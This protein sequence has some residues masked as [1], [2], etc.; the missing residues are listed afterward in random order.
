MS[1]ADIVLLIDALAWPV[2]IL[3]GIVILRRPVIEFMGRTKSVDV[4]GVKFELREKLDK[5]RSS[6]EDAAMTV[7]FSA[8]GFPGAQHTDPFAP[9]EPAGVQGAA[10]SVA[11]AKSAV[12]GDDATV[13]ALSPASA[14]SGEIIATQNPGLF[15]ASI[16]DDL[17][18]EIRAVAKSIKGE[19]TSYNEAV[20]LL[21]HQDVLTENMQEVLN[22]IHAARN[23]AVHE[24]ADS[25]TAAEAADWAGL[26]FGLRQRIDQRHRM[27]KEP[28][29]KT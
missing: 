2:A 27:L 11:R 15:L 5:A 7:L 29:E 10:G 22:E 16:F 28:E 25:M 23:I 3:I 13:F 12:A 4:K 20:K 21:V 6:A 17:S 14:Q 19:S 18:N 8:R 26:A 24:D 1:A 9:V